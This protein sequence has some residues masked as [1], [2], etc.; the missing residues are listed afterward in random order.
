MN[1]KEMEDKLFEGINAQ[2]A[3]YG[4]AIVACAQNRTWTFPRWKT[5]SVWFIPVMPAPP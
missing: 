1:E 3:A 2:I 5:R 4:Y